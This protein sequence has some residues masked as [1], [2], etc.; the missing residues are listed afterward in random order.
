MRSLLDH[1]RRID[2]SDWLC[3]RAAIRTPSMELG[4]AKN[5]VHPIISVQPRLNTNNERARQ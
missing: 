1:D 5:I 4:P 3:I 2:A